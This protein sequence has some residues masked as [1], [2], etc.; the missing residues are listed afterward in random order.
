[1]HG[2]IMMR[3]SGARLHRLLLPGTERK[4]L[5]PDETVRHV[6]TDHAVALRE[7]PVGGNANSGAEQM[8]EKRI[9]SGVIAIDGLIVGR[10]MPVVKVR[11]DDD[12]FHHTPRQMNVGMIEYGLKSHDEDVRVDH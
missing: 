6:V 10:M 5:L 2:H 8:I 9:V 4:K 7:G 1:M 3:F 12:V 11:R